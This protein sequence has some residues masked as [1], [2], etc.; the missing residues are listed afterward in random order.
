VKINP[1]K[2]AKKMT[3]YEKINEIR[4]EIISARQCFK[5]YH[6]LLDNPQINISHKKLREILH[7]CDERCGQLTDLILNGV[8]AKENDGENT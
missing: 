6:D 3:D 4:H 5:S 2:N 7:K 8:N 1:A